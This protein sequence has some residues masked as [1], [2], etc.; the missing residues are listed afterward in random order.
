MQSES[1][2]PSGGWGGLDCSSIMTPNFLSFLPSPLLKEQRK[3]WSLH[4]FLTYLDRTSPSIRSLLDPLST[5][6]AR[7]PNF[8]ATPTT[9]IT[10]IDQASRRCVPTPFFRESDPSLETKTFAEISHLALRDPQKLW[11]HASTQSQISYSECVGAS[12]YRLWNGILS[13]GSLEEVVM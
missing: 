2:T 13:F 9:S 6:N 4:Q 5:L 7:I 3:C 1:I 12:T 11:R 8:L 10:E